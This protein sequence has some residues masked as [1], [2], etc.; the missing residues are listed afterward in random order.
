MKSFIAV[1]LFI[2]AAGGAAYHALYQAPELQKIEKEKAGMQFTGSSAEELL[3]ELEAAE[4]KLDLLDSLELSRRQLV[5]WNIEQDDIYYFLDRIARDMSDESQFKVRTDGQAQLYGVPVYNYTVTGRA[6][7]RDLYYL[8]YAV[9]NSRELKSIAAFEADYSAEQTDGMIDFS[10]SMHVFYSHSPLQMQQRYME[11]D[12]EPAPVSN[13]FPG[14]SQLD[15]V[16]LIQ[17][18]N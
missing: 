6:G 12:L 7:F 18:G 11:H 8:V 15:I 5:P 1:L 10:L 9:E 4:K 3:N 17:R 13:F 16:E 14:S 2:A